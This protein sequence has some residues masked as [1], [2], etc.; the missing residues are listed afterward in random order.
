[1]RDRISWQGG[2]ILA[3]ALGLALAPLRVA[4][5]V[6]PP[7]KVELVPWAN[8]IQAITA[9]ANCG[10]H[11][12]FVATQ[13]GSIWI[14]TDS[15]T[16]RPE[17]FLNIYWLVHFAGEQGLLGLAFDPGYADNGHFYV[18]YTQPFSA[19]HNSIVSRFTV[20]VDDPDQ[21]DPNSEMVLMSIPQPGV[22]HKAGDLEFGPDGYLYLSIGDGGPQ[23]DP[24]NQGQSL[25]TRLGKILRISVNADGTWNAPATNPFAGAQGDTLPE[26][27]AYGVRN[28]FRI[29]VDPLN[30]DVWFGDVGQNSFDEV[31]RIPAGSNGLNFGWRCYEGAMPIYPTEC[32]DSSS[33]AW[34]VA[35]HANVMNGGDFCAVIG[36]KVYRGSKYPR[37]YG[38][39]LYTDYCSGV[40]RSIREEGSMGW[41]N[42]EL[43]APVWAGNTT[44]GKDSAGELYLANQVTKRIYK[45]VDRCPMPAPVLL[46]SGDSLHCSTATAYTWFHDGLE[47]PDTTAGIA[48]QGDGLYWAVTDM[49]GGCMF[50][51]DTVQ[52]IHS[53]LA[54]L[55]AT[56]LRIWPNPALDQ[57][58]VILPAPRADGWQIALYDALGR[59]VRQWRGLPGGRIS[60]QLDQVPAGQ[61]ILR[62]RSSTGR[63]HGVLGIM[64]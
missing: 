49:G 13:G 24:D 22:I 23:G 53:G 33:L 57:V 56:A 31:N 29:S 60:L 52:V 46:N 45:I 38:R 16:V 41:V 36:G 1:M 17:P 3:V 40:I 26:T 62:A 19:G 61:Y 14:V 63:I 48:V 27:Y 2:A 30:G 10:D 54:P 6:T 64:R 25:D 8:N 51:T 32:P 55:P 20:S 9:M 58:T 39:Y 28:P 7:V 42:E 59:P 5:Q 21:A 43:H 50:T 47:L 12:L 4:A 11:R 34:P 18:H 15:M 35:E 37:L 44:F